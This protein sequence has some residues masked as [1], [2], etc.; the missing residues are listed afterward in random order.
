MKFS[1][2]SIANI[3]EFSIGLI[4]VY[5]S[6]IGLSKFNMFLKDLINTNICNVFHAL[7]FS[8]KCDVYDF[9]S[10]LYNVILK[11]NVNSLKTSDCKGI[12]DAIICT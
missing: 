8:R 11:R 3:I 2:N 4:L 6:N 5:W 1:Y 7:E 10:R 12:V 9:S